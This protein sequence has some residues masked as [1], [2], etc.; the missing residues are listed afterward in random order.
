MLQSSNPVLSGD[1]DFREHYGTMAGGRSDVATLQGIV[2]RTAA[3]A[4]VCVLFGAVGYHFLAGNR[5]LTMLV[6]FA[7]FAITMGMGFVIRRNPALAAPLGF[8]F[9]AVEGI[10]LGAVTGSLDMVLQNVLGEKNPVLATGGLALPAFIITI[11]VMGSM[12]A[13]YSARII[14]PTARFKAIIGTLTMAV[15]VT[16]LASFVLSLFSVQIP[17]LS[18]GSA[19]G[20]GMAPLIGMGISLLFL[21]IASFA[22]I[23]D[24]ERC[25]QIVESGAP[26]NMEWFAAFGLIVGLAWVYFES[27]KLAFRLAIMFGNRD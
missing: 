10:F 17:F 26:K 1:A 4:I 15:M 9:A 19:F 20:S 5:S 16:Y 14:R 2:N 11:S 21:G 7:G 22:L 25:E 12:L 27:V 13:L 6:A 8:V 3:F 18:L 24:F 23:M